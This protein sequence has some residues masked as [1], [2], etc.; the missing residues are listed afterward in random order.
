MSYISLVT[1]VAATVARDHGS[2]SSSLKLKIKKDWSCELSGQEKVSEPRE[3]NQFLSSGDRAAKV[4]KRSKKAEWKSSKSCVN[5]C[6]SIICSRRS[7]VI[8]LEDTILRLKST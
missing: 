8:F 6:K 3:S 5:G 1:T 2:D 7:Y 4:L